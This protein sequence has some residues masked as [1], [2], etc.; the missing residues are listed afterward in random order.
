[1]RI[2]AL[3][4]VMEL[5]LANHHAFAAHAE[6]VEGN[7]A[8]SV[9]LVI[10]EDLQCADCARFEAILEQKI[11]P[12]YGSKVAVV[13]RDLPLGKH[14]WARPAAV[15]A[16]WVWQQDS[17]HGIAIRRELMSEQDHITAANLNAWL[18]DF[19]DRNHFDSKDILASLKDS[20]INALVDQD[21]QAAVARGVTNTPTVYVGGVAFVDPIIYEDVARALDQALAK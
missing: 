1:M 9:K 16:R 12:K 10:Y 15:A 4:I 13:H 20:R 21:R 2:A 3:L 7:A 19:A 5:T 18:A 14:D 11:L 8:S 6:V 17:E